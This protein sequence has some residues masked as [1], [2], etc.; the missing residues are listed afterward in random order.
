MSLLKTCESWNAKGNYQEWHNTTSKDKVERIA[1]QN[2]RWRMLELLKT[3][4]VLSTMF[5]FLSIAWLILTSREILKNNWRM[6]RILDEPPCRA[7][8]KSSGNKR[9]IERKRSW[10]NKVKPCDDLD[11]A[12][13]WYNRENLEL[14]KEKMNTR[15]ENYFI[16]NN[17][18]KKELITWMKQE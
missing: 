18:R 9:M 6:K 17:L 4:H 7:S 5:I 15:T 14:R 1:L 10:K 13:R 3:K 11:G 12:L 8:M 2:A 16:M